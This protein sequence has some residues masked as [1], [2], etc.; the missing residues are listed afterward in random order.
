MGSILYIKIKFLRLYF[1]HAIYIGIDTFLKKYI[2]F[3]IGF[4]S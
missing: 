1:K 4:G 2:I 3:F